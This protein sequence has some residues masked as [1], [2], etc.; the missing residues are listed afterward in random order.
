MI[1]LILMLTLGCLRASDVSGFCFKEKK[2]LPIGLEKLSD[3]LE[4]LVRVVRGNSVKSERN[5]FNLSFVDHFGKDKKS[6]ADQVERLF[7]DLKKY[8]DI[9]ESYCVYKGYHILDFFAVEGRVEEIK[10]F[11]KEFGFKS[12]KPKN[13]TNF[14]HLY[15]AR[16]EL[17]ILK[18]LDVS[19][20]DE[21][22]EDFDKYY[23]SATVMGVTPFMVA[24]YMGYREM[25]DY[26]NEKEVP[27]KDDI[28]DFISDDEGVS[29]SD[30][31]AMGGFKIGDDVNVVQT[32]FYASGCGQLD[33]VRSISLKN[34]EDE[35]RVQD[36]TPLMIAS[37]NGHQGVVRYLLEHGANPLAKDPRGMTALIMACKEGNVGCVS[38][39]LAHDS[40]NNQINILD[41]EQK[42]AFY[43]SIKCEE[44]E[45]EQILKLLCRTTEPNLDDLGYALSAIYEKCD[46][47]LFVI[48]YP[49]IND[50]N[51]VIGN[52]HLIEIVVKLSKVDFEKMQNAFTNM[53][54]RR[55]NIVPKDSK[56]N[57]KALI[58]NL[59]HKD[60]ELDQMLFVAGSYMAVGDKNIVISLQDLVGEDGKASAAASK[61]LCDLVGYGR[62]VE[63]EF[64]ME[65]L[66]SKT[67]DLS[68]LL[69]LKSEFEGF[70]GMTPLMAACQSG[71]LG[72]A[73]ILLRNGAIVDDETDNGKT[74]LMYASEMGHRNVVSL[75]LND[76]GANLHA[77][78]KD[79]KDALAWAM[80]DDNYT[81][82]NT[83][84][85]LI[86]K[87]AKAGRK[88]LDWMQEAID[89][90][91]KLKIGIDEY[92]AFE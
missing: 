13:G 62:Y 35:E 82:F 54:D 88:V 87:G 79:N 72:N 41:S 84:A 73:K 36:K 43:Y 66:K 76:A 74:A 92:G 50:V 64:I 75:L 42:G 46:S 10:K 12:Y 56:G 61:H 30:Y 63:V 39:L 32:N 68:N 29:M 9:L 58:K 55:A 16:N 1:Y 70:K 81:N 53:L 59:D 6:S 45:R 60:K 71:K 40:K 8:K 18:D 77:T 24:F 3:D 33:L 49:K 4:G 44:D 20:E 91:H 80:G 27:T 65:M 11:A 5:F 85:L 31:A 69:S 51:M 78:N 19:L 14:V 38:A 90:Q 26:L 86:K 7:N 21:V 37:Q 48:L 2:I 34:T 22:K 83:V 17:D 25:V 89:L 67:E 52:L 23:Y 47:S 57:P 28:G 15:V